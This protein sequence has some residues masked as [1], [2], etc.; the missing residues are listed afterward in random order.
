MASAAC[1]KIAGLPVEF[2]VATILEAIIAL[3][4]MPEMTTRPGELKICSTALEKFSSKSEDKFCIALASFSIVFLAISRIAV[5][6]F[7]L[8]NSII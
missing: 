8:I 2:K 1:I 3:F 4:P 6:F 5:V 7:K